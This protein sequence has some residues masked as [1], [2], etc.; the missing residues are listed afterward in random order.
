MIEN[1]IYVF[2]REIMRESRINGY[3]KGGIATAEI[4]ANKKLS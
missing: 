2:I 1:R 3:K 4:M